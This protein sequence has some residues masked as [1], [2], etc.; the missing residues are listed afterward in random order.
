VPAGGIPQ[1]LRGRW[2]AITAASA[3]YQ[4]CYWPIFA[5]TTAPDGSGVGLIALG[6]ALVPFVFLVAA[7]ATQHPNAP[8]ATL[9]AMGWF[10]LV[11][12][13]VGVFVPI[14]GVCLGVS[15]GAVVAL[16]PLPERDT[17][18][19]RYLTVAGVAAYLLVLLAF[20]PGFLV[21]SGAVLPLAVH[22]MVDQAV[23]ERDR[24]RARS[25]A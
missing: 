18:R 25:E 9:R 6:L 17:R 20:S 8:G 21:I 5:G 12:L 22:G 16:A 13:P 24:S 1:T 7:F 2:L 14:I 23:E 10:L 19:T 3:V 11:G 4:F 15:L